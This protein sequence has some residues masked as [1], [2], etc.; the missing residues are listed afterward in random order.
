[1]KKFGLIGFPLSHSFSQKYFSNKFEKEG[2]KGIEYHLL[3]LEDIRQ[4]PKILEDDSFRGINVTIP[5]KIAVLPFL[6]DIDLDAKGV[7]AVNCIKI[8]GTGIN[9]KLIG[10]NT[11]AYGFQNSISP[12]LEPHHQ[13][14]LILGNGGAAKA[15]KYVFEKLGISYKLVSRKPQQGMFTYED[16]TEEVLN[17]YHIIVNTSPLGTYPNIEAFPN[18]PYQ[19]IT[20]KHILYDLVYNPAET[21][22]LAKG[23]ANGA[24]T[25]NGYEMLE[26]QAIK[27]WEIWNEG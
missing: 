21:V 3:S 9:K 5:H 11:D 22:F 10:Y 19:F 8:V 16:L 25:K 2:I 4:F 27:S 6:H 20:N 26:L 15:V 7:G 23:K 1:M 18:I 12:L 24:K 13:K 17:A 14:A